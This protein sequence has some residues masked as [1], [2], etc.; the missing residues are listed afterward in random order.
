MI[1]GATGDKSARLKIQVRMKTT[2]GDTTKDLIYLVIPK[3]VED[4]ILGYDAHRTF[5]MSIDTDNEAITL[6]EKLLT[7]IP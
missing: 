7:P 6:K 5:K 2:T 4:C 1:K 3:L